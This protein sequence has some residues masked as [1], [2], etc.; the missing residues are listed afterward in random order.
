MRYGHF[1][2]CTVLLAGFLAV[3]DGGAAQSV[4]G[5]VFD[6]YTGEAVARVEVAV[7]DSAGEPVGLAVSDSA[8]SFH[9][10]LE[11]AGHYRLTARATGYDRLAVDSLLIGPDQEVVVELRLGPRPLEVEGLTVV[12]RRALGPPALREFYERLDRHRK[13][14]RGLVLDRAVL[15]R[16][17]AQTGARAL[18]RESFHVREHAAFGGGRIEVRRLGARFGARPWCEP[19][20]FLDGLPVDAGTL[21]SIPASALAGIELYRGVHEVPARFMWADNAMTCG[22]IL[23]WTRRDGG[24]RPLSGELR[25]FQVGAFFATVTSDRP[26]G[27]LDVAA[28]GIELERGIARSMVGWIQLGLIRPEYATLCVPGLAGSCD[29]GGAPWMAI[30]GASLFPTGRELALAPYV[31]GGV[32]VASPGSGIEAVHL[33]RAG[34]E[35]VPGPA[36]VRLELRSDPNGWG[37]GVGV[38]F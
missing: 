15:D 36:H 9:V 20:M 34:L 30:V 35:L 6:G 19:A 33:V 25:P 21:R 29:V 3:P 32:G 22:A 4:R 24:G 12:T 14:G 31:G 37:V 16:H 13:T 18:A 8:G 27:S 38:M 10:P 5:R 23:A 26:D 7:L 28:L 2:S 11:E 1:L 17:V